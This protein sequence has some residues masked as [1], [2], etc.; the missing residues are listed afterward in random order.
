[1][2]PYMPSPD[3]GS[4][5]PGL[6]QDTEAPPAQ[7][8]PF[9]PAP[10]SEFAGDGVPAGVVDMAKA[11]ELGED[12]IIN[13]VKRFREESAKLRRPLEDSWRHYEGCYYAQHSFEEKEAWQAAIAIPEVSN[14]IRAAVAGMQGALLDT[15]DWFTVVKQGKYADDA[16]VNFI[17]QWLHLV[18]DDVDMVD[19]LLECWT[20]SFLYGTGWLGI[21]YE[22][23]IDRRPRVVERPLY[24][25]EQQAMMAMQQGLPL[26]ETTVQTDAL[27]RGR[28]VLRNYSPFNVFPDP[29]CHTFDDAKYVIVEDL[30]DEEELLAGREMGLYEFD[31]LGAPASVLPGERDGSISPSSWADDQEPTGDR[32]RHLV[33]TYYGNFYDSHG[34]MVLENWKCVIANERT[35]LSIGANPLWSGKFPIVCST[36]LPHREMLWGRSLV[37]Y[38]STVQEEMTQLTNLILDDSKYSVLG[39]FMVDESKSDEP[40]DIDSIE[41]GRVYRGRDNFI[42][43]L[44]FTTQSNLAWPIIQ[45]LQ[46]I[47]D[48]STAIGE[49]QAPGA[50]TS[51][52]RASATEVQTRSQAGSAYMQAMSR[53]LEVN[54]IE[55]ML[56]LILEFI[57][58]FG[59]DDA[60]PKI[61]DLLQD[62]GGPQILYD[63][64]E[65]FKILDQPVKIE[66]KG[67]SQV[68]S[69]ESMNA[70]IFELL[71]MS[72]QLGMPPSSQ[73]PLFYAAITNMG[74]DPQQLGYPADAA[75]MEQLQMQMQMQQENG[76][77]QAGGQIPPSASGATT[78]AP[79]S[80]SQT[81]SM[82]MSGT[83]SDGSQN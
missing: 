53:R 64:V 49:F 10:W 14:K 21:Q 42:S 51:R 34:D 68:F 57:L 83:N 63:P 45:H 5:P 31:D 54:D 9:T 56:D 1:M 69:R 35:L 2:T 3:G 70:K 74:L 12:E 33:Q 75:A 39:A 7:E 81:E 77:Q 29:Y 11:S 17:D 78:A 32:R 67:I 16:A 6:A 26:S 27:A 44:N 8:L 65:R 18:V 47:G 43:K 41:P 61:T 48:T 72:Q 28:F 23:Y 4:P 73:I 58:Q 79:P 40:G 20:S 46:K 55:P 66:A 62:F 25:D 71:G 80:P 50:P 82:P 13:C 15:P 30:V 36:P 24:Q 76:G 37:E 52:G 19:R 59:G 38:D 60:N 22:E